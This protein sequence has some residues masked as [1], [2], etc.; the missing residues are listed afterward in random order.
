MR[1]QTTCTLTQSLTPY[2]QSFD[3]DTLAYAILCMGPASSYSVDMFK[4]TLLGKGTRA[5][6]GLRRGAYGDCQGAMGGHNPEMMSSSTARY[7]SSYDRP[8]V[9]SNH[10][11]GVEG[12]TPS[13]HPASAGVVSRKAASLSLSLSLFL[14]TECDFETLRDAGAARNG[15]NQD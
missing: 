10:S 8:L 6:V 1:S 7:V 2:A 4:V 14:S 9:Y 11:A 13:S 3:C 15:G 5:V 12:P